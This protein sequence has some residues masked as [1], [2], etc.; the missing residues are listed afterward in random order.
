MTQKTTLTLTHEQWLTMYLS[1]E[2]GPALD[3]LINLAPAEWVE[4]LLADYYD[5]MQA[6]D[7][8]ED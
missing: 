1:I 8:E 6:I 5:G 2:E 3:M 4:S 7:D